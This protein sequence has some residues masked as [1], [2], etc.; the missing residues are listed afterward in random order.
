MKYVQNH[1]RETRKTWRRETS[2][3]TLSNFLVEEHGMT[4]KYG[5][6]QCNVTSLFHW[7]LN[8]VGTIPGA[9]LAMCDDMYYLD[10]TNNDITGTIPDDISNLAKLEYIY[11]AQNQLS[12]TI[13]QSY[14]ER[15]SLLFTLDLSH[16]QLTG[17]I[18]LFTNASKLALLLLHGNLLS[19]VPSGAFDGLYVEFSSF[20]F[21]NIASQGGTN[22]DFELVLAEEA[23]RGIP[24][25]ETI[26]LTGN[27]VR[28][29]PRHL[30]GSNVTKQ[31]ARINLVGLGISTI[32]DNAFP[33]SPVPVKIDLRGNYIL[34]MS[35]RAFGT[36]VVG[37]TAEC[38]D[39]ENWDLH[40]TTGEI[41]TCDNFDDIGY[42]C[43]VGPGVC[44]PLF[45][46]TQG[47]A[48][49]TVQ[50]ACCDYG[51][52]HKNGNDLLVD[53]F[54]LIFCTAPSTSGGN[55]TCSCS[56]P[57]ARYDVAIS[58]CVFQCEPGEAWVNT[59]TESIE[60][61]TATGMCTKC[62]VGT[63]SGSGS[64]PI[65]LECTSGRYSPEEGAT[66]CDDCPS[67]LVAEATRTSQCTACS[68]GRSTE[69]SVT[70][71]MCTFAYLGSS[72]CKTPIGAFGFGVV[73]AVV[74]LM[75]AYCFL[76][77][78]KRAKAARKMLQKQSTLIRGK[79]AEIE[80]LGQG[81]IIAAEEITYVKR[82][83]AGGFG[84][85]W[86][87]VL[88]KK[89]E[90]AV[91]TM[92][93]STL[94][95]LEKD[96]EIQFLRRA[97]HPRLV[98]FLGC[99]YLRDDDKGMEDGVKSGVFVVLEFCDRGDLSD[100]LYKV[101]RR[102]P[103]SWEDRLSLLG[104]IADGMLHLHDHLDC[105]HRDLKSANCLL[106]LEDG[107]VR[108]KVADFGLSKFMNHVDPQTNEKRGKNTFGTLSRFIKRHGSGSR[109]EGHL[110]DALSSSGEKSK[111]ISAGKNFRTAL[112]CS[113]D[114]AS[115]PS[116]NFDVIDMSQPSG[117][118]SRKTTRSR[119]SSSTIVQTMTNGVGTPVYMAPEI[120]RGMSS[121]DIHALKYSG[122]I[123][124]Y[125][126]GM[127]LYETLELN[128]PWYQIKPFFL[129][130]LEESV[131]A[132]RRPQILREEDAPCGFVELMNDCWQQDATQR[133]VFDEITRRISMIKGRYNAR[134]SKSKD[135]GCITTTDDSN[136]DGTGVH[137]GDL[138]AF[139]L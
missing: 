70:C 107:R 37:T 52:G 89:Y 20:F 95:D 47:A 93:N 96:P 23:F 6:D 132:G 50:D 34:H 33:T 114:S 45:A 133:P 109:K 59:T 41:Y 57:D 5:T 88:R 84:E 62:D 116:R 13:P 28:T 118:Q 11:L 25:P 134:A 72:D 44:V 103:P 98:M 113:P 83:A 108:A 120:M 3:K 68:W 39:I 46:N 86:K 94:V 115:S 53:S 9:S 124:V 42:N 85:V 123:D 99:G 129:Y 128:V 36:G 8:L 56:D 136:D 131:V 100:Y 32:E 21:V 7:N 31:G 101:K 18:P 27:T 110:K 79:D 135:S 122:Q 106:S 92:Y 1:S 80:K 90:V 104:D 66:E 4:E 111:S 16:N 17:S 14:P 97:R 48:G 65:C 29:I 60:V 112:S 64:W 63:Y 105:V 78:Q 61:G 125:S 127:I 58:S 12:G 38:V 69:D 139:P 81:W 76:R 40:L 26:A 138:G 19:Y 91:K 2:S 30:F 119:V 121:K 35:P 15:L 71:N 10:F 130:I 77:C 24:N 102:K 49:L 51:G 117:G 22:E 43:M 126:F 75:I 87:G 74:F 67:G 73:I 54:S 55:V 137:Q 82:L